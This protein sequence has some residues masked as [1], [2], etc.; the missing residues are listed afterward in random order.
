MTVNSSF[1]ALIGAKQESAAG[2]MLQDFLPDEAARSE[3]Q[4]RPRVP[5][6]TT[7]RQCD[8]TQIPVEIIQRPVDFAGKRHSAVAVRDLRDRKKAESHIRFLAHH[9]MLTGLPNRNTFNARLDE[10]IQKHLITGRHLAVLCLD[11]DRFKEVNDLFGHAAGDSLLQTVAKCVTSVLEDHQMMARLGGD[12]F[13]VIAPDLSDPAQAG[14][15]AETI[16]DAMR[17]EN[18][19]A[20][21]AALLSTSIGIATLPNDALDRTA[22]LNHADTALYRAKAEGRGTYRFFEVTMGAQ[23]RERRLIEHDLRHAISRRELRLV[24][25]PQTRID[26]KEVVGFEALLRWDHPERGETSP[27]IFVPIAEETGLI[28]QIGEWVLRAAC[29]EAAAWSRPLSVAV[30]VSAM[31]LLPPSRLLNP[32]NRANL[33]TPRR[34]ATAPHVPPIERPVAALILVRRSFAELVSASGMEG[35]MCE[36]VRKDF[37]K[38]HRAPGAG[39]KPPPKPPTAAEVAAGAKPTPNQVN[40]WQRLGHR[41]LAG[42]CRSATAAPRRGASA[43]TTTTAS[44][45]PRSSMRLCAGAPR[46]TSTSMRRVA[47]AL[48][49]ER[50]SRSRSRSRPTGAGRRGQRRGRALAA[51][52]GRGASACAPPRRCGGWSSGS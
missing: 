31:I 37:G 27:S 21:S 30:N 11:L 15:L 7:L 19:G 52:E 32:S 24:Y 50:G 43:S 26:T 46:N 44:R 6:E 48:D 12:E 38:V 33:L 29:R 41:Q 8:G 23:V 25:Q 14:K 40:Y 4:E 17:I 51:R 13:A 28:L 22:L 47:K 1:A 5:I 42:A 9:D 2:R 45:A 3:L 34:T 39:F 20:A 36:R 18:E 49:E 35:R 10:E 16:L